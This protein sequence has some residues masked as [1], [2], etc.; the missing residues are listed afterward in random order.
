MTLINPGTLSTA[1]SAG[2]A[3]KSGSTFG[4]LLT[5][6]VHA[7]DS[8]QSTANQQITG[9]MTGQVSVTQAMMAVSE[10]QSSLDVATSVRNNVVQAYQ[11]IM[12]MSV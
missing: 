8:S 7:L 11:S 1:S 6:A 4:S 12:N 2:S 10:A 9:A 5:G 3:G